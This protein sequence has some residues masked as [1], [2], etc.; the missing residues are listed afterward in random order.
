MIQLK[1]IVIS[2]LLLASPITFA[3]A[4]PAPILQDNA[5]KSAPI[6]TLDKEKS[7]ITFHGIQLGVSFKGD[8]NKFSGSILHDPADLSK[9]KITITIAIANAITG[10]LQRDTNLP[11]EDWFDSLTHPE[12]IFT[13]TSLSLIE[14]NKYN[15]N[16][17]LTLKTITHPLSFPI[18]LDI[19]EKGK[20]H[21]VG[22]FDLNR[23]DYN[24]GL[25][26][27]TNP[28]WVGINVVV[29][30]DITAAKSP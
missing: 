18:T 1:K 11:T 2:A 3:Q 17:N 19:D 22:E 12:A 7:T 26:A 30:F 13:S 4:S 9:T 10:N 15:L 16:G 23:L 29:K 5:T 27:W 20:A 14:G 21:A 25:G 8:F 6:W 28:D 24:V